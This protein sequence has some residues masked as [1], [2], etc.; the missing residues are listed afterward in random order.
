MQFITGY[1]HGNLY[2]K[3]SVSSTFGVFLK[4]INGTCELWKRYYV[5]VSKESD[6]LL[7]CEVLCPKKMELELHA[8]L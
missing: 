5:I 6:V 4:V 7:L 2:L 1:P 3:S 8:Y